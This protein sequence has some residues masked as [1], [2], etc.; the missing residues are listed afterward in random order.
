MPKANTVLDQADV[1]AAK[2]GGH[3]IPSASV[4]SAHDPKVGVPAPEQSGLELR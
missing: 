1:H 4:G 3:P 2:Q